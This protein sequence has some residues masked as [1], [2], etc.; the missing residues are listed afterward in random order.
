MPR[1][2]VEFLELGNNSYRR[3]FYFHW[4]SS[5]VNQFETSSRLKKN[6]NNNLRSWLWPKIFPPKLWS[7]NCTSSAYISANFSRNFELM[8]K[9][10]HLNS[11]LWTIFWIHSIDYSSFG[12]I[13]AHC[14]RKTCVHSFM[15]L[16]F[17]CRLS[18]PKARWSSSRLPRHHCL[19]LP[20][21]LSLFI[22]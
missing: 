5:S 11:K 18:T 8:K 7:K 15:F 16:V 21:F 19:G 17:S 20:L 3:A 6:N 13:A 4:S 2:A 1:D 14:C 22:N 10:K 9:K 12:T